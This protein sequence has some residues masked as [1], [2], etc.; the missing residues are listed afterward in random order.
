MGNKIQ[1]I[2]DPWGRYHVKSAQAK[3]PAAAIELQESQNNTSYPPSLRQPTPW[4][5]RL[6]SITPKFRLPL[7]LLSGAAITAGTT[8]VLVKHVQHLM[9]TAQVSSDPSVWIHK[10]RDDGYGACYNGCDNCRDVSYVY[11][12]CEKTARAIVPG[13]NCNGTSMWNWANRYPTECL[14]ALGVIYKAEALTKRKQNYR[15][16]LAV[17]ILTVIAGVVGAVIVFKLW[18]RW[19][20][21]YQPSSRWPASPPP[22]TAPYRASRP[23]T[24]R[25][26]PFFWRAAAAASLSGTSHAYPCWGFSSSANQYF[27]HANNTISGVVHGWTSSCHTVT[28]ACGSTCSS[29]GTSGPNSGGT[30]TCTTDFCYRD[31]EDEPPLFFVNYTMRRVKDCGFRL[32]DNVESEVNLRIGH[33]L[34][35]RNWRVKISVNRYNLTGVTDP[36]VLCLW[37]IGNH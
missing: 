4:S 6:R 5:E 33:P 28:Y 12:A 30:T 20:P 36:S 15:N 10:A 24:R 19:F 16:Q 1:D 26:W 32:V 21:T 14:E 27:T 37:D 25:K 3:T 31:E 8:Y 29:S 13:I 22:Y 18:G 35:E 2:D 9:A 17:I 23:K 11:N 34:I 7:A